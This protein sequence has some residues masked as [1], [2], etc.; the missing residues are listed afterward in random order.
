MTEMQYGDILKN[1][2]AEIDALDDQIIALLA[3]RFEV[4]AKVAQIKTANNI[5]A[6]L[7]DRV[8]QVK[9]TAEK[10][11]VNAGL[12]GKFVR[13]LYARIIDHACALEE[14]EISRK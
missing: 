2:R 9:D 12:D 11:A 14:K 5:P 7:P 8:E 13:D 10:R 4:V 1:F 6:V 3:K